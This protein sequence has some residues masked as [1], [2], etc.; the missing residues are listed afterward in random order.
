MPLDPASPSVLFVRALLGESPPPDQLATLDP[1]WADLIQ[2]ALK[3]TP[4]ARRAALVLAKAGHTDLDRLLDVLSGHPAERPWPEPTP[5]DRPGLPPFPVEVLPHWLA[6]YIRAEARATQTPLDLAGLLS[7]AVLSSSLA[8]RVEL[9]PW[10][11]WLE[12][13]NLFL[14]VVLPPG[15]RKSA[16]FASVT[17]PLQQFEAAAAVAAAPRIAHARRQRHMAEQAL[18]RAQHAA[19]IAPEDRRPQLLALVER[20]ADELAAVELPVVPRLIVDDCSPERLA[21]LL[22]EQG[23]RLAI[24]SPEGGFFDLIAGRYS[25]TGAPNLDHVLKGHAGDPIVVDRV[26][27]PG[28]IVPRPA[29]TIGLAVQPDV[30]RG[31]VARPGFHGRG[32]LA[33]FL[34]AVPGATLGARDVDAEPVPESLRACYHQRIR[35]LLTLLPQR[36][37]LTAQHPSPTTRHPPLVLP[38]DPFAAARLRDFARAVEPRLAPAGDL[39]PLVDWG[40]KLVGAVARIAGLLH[41]ASLDLPVPQNPEPDTQT[42]APVSLE[43]VDAA[44]ILADHLTAHARAA[45][46]AMGAD[47]AVANI[48]F[49]LGWLRRSGLRTFTRRDAQRAARPRL[50][51]AADLDAALDQLAEHGYIRLRP[52]PS[53]PGPGRHPGPTYD[54]HPSLAPR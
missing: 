15:H 47:P 3:A 25:T 8:G 11:D 17:Q 20:R 18:L 26:G 7:L 6:N 50:N 30:L 41:L 46:A 28:E 44:C 37:S 40:S 35:A 27:R 52:S 9:N 48:P 13:L 49:L 31:L 53:R 54:V 29:L 23:G 4:T 39:E 32:L 43:A 42:A 51:T 45:Y 10:G 1:A 2:A 36:P 5:F 14:M 34:Y 33:R 19:A 16:V 24:L 12:P 38:F 21:M 22:A